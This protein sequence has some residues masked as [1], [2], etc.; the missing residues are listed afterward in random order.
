MKFIVLFTAALLVQTSWS[1]SM[2][3][4]FSNKTQVVLLGLDFTQAKFIGKD[5]FRDPEGLKNHAIKG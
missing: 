5:A 2:S 1:Q 4:F 3:D